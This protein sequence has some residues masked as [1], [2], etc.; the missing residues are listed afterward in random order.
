MTGR[1]TVRIAG[2][3][4]QGINSVGEVVAKSFKKAGLYTFSYREYPSLIRGGHAFQQIEV[5][6]APISAPCKQCDVMVCLSRVSFHAYFKGVRDGG[7]IIHSIYRLDWKDEEKEWLE[8]HHVTEQYV[9]AEQLAEDSGG[10]RLM[11][12]TVLVGTIWKMF[13]L[14]IE[15]AQEILRAAFA[16]KPQY[17]DVNLACLAKG[18][19]QVLKGSE[20][21]VIKPIGDG[22]PQKSYLLTGNHA[23]AYGAVAAGVRAYYSYPMTPSSSILTYLANVQHETKMVVKQADDEIAAAQLAM[24]SMFMGT[25]ALTSTSGGGFD[26]MTESLSLAG[27]TETPFVCVIGQRPGPATGL[28]TWTAASDLL[29][30]VFSGHGEFP[31]VVL[32]ASDAE[33]GYLLVQKAFNLAEV[34]QVPVLLLTEKQIAESWFQVP[35]F[36]ADLPIER[37]LADASAMTPADRYKLTENGVSPRWLPGSADATYIANSDEH[38]PDGSL[39][40][41]AEPSKAMYSKRLKKMETIKLALP[42]PEL[43]GPAKADLTFV[44]WGSTKHAMLDAMSIMKTDNAAKTFNYLHYEYMYPL[45]TQKFVDL[46]NNN[47]RLILIENNAMGQLGLLLTQETG[48]A[49]KETFLK[50]D[51]RPFFVEDIIE[52]VKGRT[53]NGV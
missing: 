10:K 25:R 33:S 41:D 51:G 48:H 2:E 43:F 53:S 40:E 45:H 20:A 14:P 46:M 39:T 15:P 9:D 21:F 38:L 35:K 50:Y 16:K 3:S 24:G 34:Y 42:E 32:A 31:R 49:F 8:Q 29:L 26:L 5:A 12:N 17:I 47:A 30:A 52:F 22:L 28:P 11:S 6:N 1:L 37:G 36:P 13:G 19:E 7:T 27:M 4:G 18:Y 44:G 23:I